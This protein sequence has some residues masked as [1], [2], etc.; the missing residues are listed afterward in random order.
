[1][2]KVINLGI[3]HVAEQIFE[4]FDTPGLIKC[5]EVSETWREL[6][7]NVLIKRPKG[8]IYMK[9]FEACESRKTKVAQLLLED[10]DDDELFQ[11]ALVSET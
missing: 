2:D 6:A 9:I 4:S 8:K 7:G 11:C 5:M 3:P 1:M 10:L